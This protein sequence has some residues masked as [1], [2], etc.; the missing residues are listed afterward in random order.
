MGLLLVDGRT[1]AVRLRSPPRTK[2]WMLRTSAARR[3]RP[4][5]RPGGP[6]WPGRCAPAPHE[7]PQRTATAGRSAR[8]AAGSARPR[9]GVSGCR[10][11]AGAPRCAAGCRPPSARGAGRGP[12]VPRG[13]SPGPLGSAVRRRLLRRADWPRSGPPRARRPH[14]QQWPGPPP[15]R[16]CCGA[17]HARRTRPR[18]RPASRSSTAPRGRRPARSGHLPRAHPRRRPLPTAPAA[19][20]GS[21]P[22]RTSAAVEHGVARA[23]SGLPLADRVPAQAAVR[24]AA[25]ADDDAGDPQPVQELPQIPG[26]GGSV[27]DLLAQP[28]PRRQRMPG[29]GVG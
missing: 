16:C 28:V 29:V 13:R 23:V 20:A 9:C 1:I 22:P 2:R 3:R 19:W 8:R 12:R 4:A 17:G 26:A 18:Q 24:V 6:R 25:L 21:G 15:W 5:P 11:P 7:G 27:L 10:G 14:H